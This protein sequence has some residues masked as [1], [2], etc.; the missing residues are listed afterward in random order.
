MTVTFHKRLFKLASFVQRISRCLH[1]YETV[2]KISNG[3]K[4]SP[5]FRTP[6]K[7][8]LYVQAATGR[9]ASCIVK[10]VSDIMEKG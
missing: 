10:Y 1:I 3:L 6:N 9:V 8:R 4:C 2:M 5:R 7:K